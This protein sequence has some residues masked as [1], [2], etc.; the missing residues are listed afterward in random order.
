MNDAY[1]YTHTAQTS[2]LIV[3]K[4][5]PG[6]RNGILNAFEN[7]GWLGVIGYMSGSDSVIFS[8]FDTINDALTASAL[9]LLYDCN[10]TVYTDVIS[11]TVTFDRFYTTVRDI[12]GNVYD[13]EID[14]YD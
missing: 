3:S 14:M 11:L 1:T 9:I 8:E 2:D 10:M 6:E 4:I 7:G 5:S 13:I 12:L